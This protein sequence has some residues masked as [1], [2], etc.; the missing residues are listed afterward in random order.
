MGCRGLST[1]R[2]QLPQCSVRRHCACLKHL[3]MQ[4]LSEALLNAVRLRESTVCRRPCRVRVIPG[5][6]VLWTFIQC[7]CLMGVPAGSCQCSFPDE[8][9]PLQ[10]YAD[11]ARLRGAP[12]M[13]VGRMVLHGCGS[14]ARGGSIRWDWWA[15]RTPVVEVQ[16]LPR[17]WPRSFRLSKVFDPV[18][19][20]DAA[21]VSI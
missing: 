14:N 5:G 2:V 21:A 12:K 3:R 20:A 6:D 7:S 1:S 11:A 15:I 19:T 17:S 9:R 13:R 8:V 16:N 18:G 4:L 10:R